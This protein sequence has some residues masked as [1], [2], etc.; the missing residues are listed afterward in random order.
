M[1]LKNFRFVPLFQ[2]PLDLKM[3]SMNDRELRQ[4]VEG[5]MLKFTNVV[6]GWQY[7]YFVLDPERGSLD[8]YIEKVR[9]SFIFNEIHD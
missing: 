9:I 7:R 6:K 3:F 1:S 4:P 5:N 8:Y 2:T